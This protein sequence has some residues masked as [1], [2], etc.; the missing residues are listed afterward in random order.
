MAVKRLV[1]RGQL[2]YGANHLVQPAP[3]GV[4][5]VPSPRRPAGRRV[6][7]HGKGVRL[8]AS[9]G[10]VGQGR[11]PR[12]RRRGRGCPVQDIYIPAKKTGDAATGDTVAV[13][14]T[15]PRPRR[16]RPPRRDR[17][18][19][20]TADAPVRRHLFRVERSG[21]RPDRRHAVRPAD[22]RG[23]SRG[24]ERQRRRQSRLRDGP[25][26]LAAARRR[27]RDY[28]SARAARQAGR[29]HAVDHP[30]VRP[31][32]S[33]LP[34]TPSTRP[35]TRPTPSTNRFPRGP[36][37]PDRRDD[38]DDRSGRR[39]R[40]R[41]RD[42]A[43]AARKRPLAAGRPYCRRVALRPARIRRWIARRRTGPPASICPT[44]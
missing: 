29:R 36:L 24:Q 9:R 7:S 13:R 5:G 27:R 39:P 8:R 40:F 14:L 33:S 4:S 19:D 26:P 41:R 34:K 17:R 35:G 25:L 20:R 1:H 32:R 3:S 42:L 2:A 21:L 23:R 31:A 6:P 37:R 11:R 22:L 30:R 12:S 10:D 16:S 43:G 18:S 15:R 38:R 28:R 44:A